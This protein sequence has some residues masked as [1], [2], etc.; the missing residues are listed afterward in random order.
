M[1]KEQKERLM[2]AEDENFTIIEGLKSEYEDK[3]REMKCL[4][5]KQLQNLQE[6]H[7]QALL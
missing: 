3:L 4:H 6:K 7:E 5:E 1:L 2:Q